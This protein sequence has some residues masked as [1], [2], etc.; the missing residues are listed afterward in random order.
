MKIRYLYCVS[1]ILRAGSLSIGQVEFVRYKRNTEA[2]PERVEGP[3][4][5]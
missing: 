5:E 4:L 3:F 2:C 1:P